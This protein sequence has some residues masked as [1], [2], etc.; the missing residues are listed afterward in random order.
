MCRLIKLLTIIFQPGSRKV[1]F[2]LPDKY[3]SDG[4]VPR[5]VMDIGVI[6]LELEFQSEGREF[7]VD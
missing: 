4:M 6:N 5:K 7:I 3:I 1:R 2:S